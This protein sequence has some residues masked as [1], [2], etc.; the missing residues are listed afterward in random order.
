M[1]RLER[2]AQTI[3]DPANR[4]GFTMHFRVEDL[5]LLLLSAYVVTDAFLSVGTEP[6]QDQAKQAVN[7]VEALT[8]EDP[9]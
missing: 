3:C 6:N 9:T 1:T 8:Q 2:I 5:D 7:C 4:R